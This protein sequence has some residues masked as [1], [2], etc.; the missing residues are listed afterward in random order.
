MAL[1]EPGFRHDCTQLELFILYPSSGP[2]LATC[3]MYLSALHFIVGISITFW[4]LS[5]NSAVGSPDG[6]IQVILKTSQAA[7][8]FGSYREHVFSSDV[9]C[10]TNLFVLEDRAVC[11]KRLRVDF[12]RIDDGDGL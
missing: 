4:V 6:S 1:T 9:E 8:V 2:L 11:L 7:A 5:S 3:L 10:K 12:A